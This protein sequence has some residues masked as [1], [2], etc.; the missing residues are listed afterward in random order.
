[1]T[2]PRPGRRR[3]LVRGLLLSLQIL[4][5]HPLRTALSV[6][7]LLV[8][9]A[10]VIV[11]V[12]V[13]EGAERRV[14]RRMQ[15]MGTNLLVVSAAP[16]P[17]VAGRPR[18]VAIHTT[19][20]TADAG[21]I[22]EESTLALAA[23]PA[24]SRSVVV[25]SE[26]VN[27]TTTLVG[28]TIAGLRIRNIEA[29]SG[30][31]FD[32]QE[33]GERA[34]V[35]LLGRTV[36]RALFGGTDPVGRLIRIGNVPFE[37]IGVTRPLGTDPDGADMDARVVIPLETA[38]RRVLNVPYIHSIF[39]QG[40]S[41]AELGELE[42][43]VR[44]TLRRVLDVRSGM[45]EPFIIQN[46][47]VRV[48]TERGTAR[49]MNRL[50]AGVTALALLLGGIGIVG[51]LLMSVRERTREIGLRRALGATRRDIRLQFVL[52]S[53]M[54][55]AAGGGA[56][57]IGGLAVAGAAAAFGPWELVMP[58]RAAF[59]G[60]ACSMLL[61]LVVGVIPAARAARLEPIA[62]LRAS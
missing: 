50:A 25:R 33:A 10:A 44:E 16:A 7:G 37:V 17:R 62:A 8:G 48:R 18:Q 60:L 35:A 4:G 55:A 61:G 59:V 13:S 39:V 15:A 53:A 47:A 11:M 51:V 21:V 52:E 41:I 24:V 1:M 22:V 23:A 32:D 3:R 6:S 27:T 54:L 57:M 19:L 12:A 9:V 29:E 40:R 45:P 38:M 5:A 43:Q 2:T 20:R 49:A 42:R 34:R 28:T 31:L 26:G 36:V 14:L 30:R 56:G 58:W 46:Q